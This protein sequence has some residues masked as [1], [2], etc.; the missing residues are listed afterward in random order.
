MPKIKIRLEHWTML[1]ALFL[2]LLLWLNVTFRT[3]YEYTLAVPLKLVNI[4]KD[5]VPLQLLP[6]HVAVKAE[7][8]GRDLFLLKFDPF[9]MVIDGGS[10]RE[11]INT[12]VM[13]TSALEIPKDIHLKNVWI[14]DPKS[15]DIGFDRLAVKKVK[16]RNNV[17]VVPHDGWVVVGAPMVNPPEI[18]VTGPAS[19]LNES[20]ILGTDSL[21]LRNVSQNVSTEV[22]L[23]KYKTGVSC[24]V[25]TVMVTVAVQRLVERELT[26]V[27]VG[28]MNVPNNIKVVLDQPVIALTVAGGDSLVSALRKEDLQVSVDYRKIEKNPHVGFAALIS[29]PENMRLVKAEPQKFKLKEK[30]ILSR[31]GR[32][33]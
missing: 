5:L 9:V 18:E 22:K 10:F 33:G 12:V 1:G 26:G 23:V 20:H 32:R 7:A 31:R 4:P 15:L 21:V 8:N 16:V 25:H 11:G 24:A 14:E 3:S 2:A 29:L 28:I 30:I 6:S 17:A 27:P 13:R 19:L